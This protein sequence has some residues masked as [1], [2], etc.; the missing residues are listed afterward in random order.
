M[1]VEE[2]KN[3]IKKNMPIYQEF[4]AKIIRIPSIKGEPAKGAPFGKQ[5]REALQ[6]ASLVL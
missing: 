3:K 2:L 5:P 4:L 1:K 6:Q